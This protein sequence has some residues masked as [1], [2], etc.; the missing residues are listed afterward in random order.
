MT[1]TTTMHLPIPPQPVD[2]RAI[3]SHVNLLLL[4]GMDTTLEP[5]E[6]G[7]Y[8][9]ACPFCGGHD[10]FRVRPYAAKAGR[11]NCRHCTGA[12]DDEESWPDAVEY[13]ARRHE[14]SYLDACRYLMGPLSMPARPPARAAAT[15]EIA[16]LPLPPSS[17]WQ[18][19]AAEAAA[20]SH[21]RLGF[22]AAWLEQHQLM[23]AAPGNPALADAP[24]AAHAFL[25]LRQLGLR[26]TT[27][28]QAGL[29][30]N[31]AW[32]ELDGGHWLAAGITIPTHAGGELWGLRVR[33]NPRYP[34]DTRRYQQLPGP[35]TRIVYNLEAL[36]G[37]VYG[38]L[39]EDELDALLL[40]QEAGGFAGV[41]AYPNPPALP[42]RWWRA[43]GH[44]RHLF[45]YAPDKKMP[46]ERWISALRGGPANAAGPAAYRAQ[47][48]NLHG[49]V[50][51]ALATTPD[52]ERLAKL[53]L[54]LLAALPGEPPKKALSAYRELAEVAGPFHPPA[55]PPGRLSL[56]R[57]A[58]DW[59]EWTLYDEG[60]FVR[61]L[62]GEQTRAASLGQYDP[63]LLAA[64]EL[65]KR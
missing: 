38:I 28:W 9:G 65:V 45:I 64:G 63:L 30:F 18:K 21:E 22:G 35:R 37:Q 3:C 57:V 55:L 11:W 10:R 8:A 56:V 58:E 20:R 6:G 53:A 7:E 47:G 17:A 15:D 16:G 52:A 26:P 59:S 61:N 25:Y 39:V 42:R 13:A 51:A 12:G 24:E 33:V 4:V 43:L 2:D 46:R 49:W 44:L 1:S 48:G 50:R 23:G 34:G 60:R 27:I 40:H 54:E 36:H 62:N 32:E 19:V 5:V 41:G 31:P 14:V 29:G